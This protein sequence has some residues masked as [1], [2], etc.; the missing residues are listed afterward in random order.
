MGGLSSI[1]RLLVPSR[2]AGIELIDS[3]E[4][5]G[6]DFLASFRDIRKINRY[7]GGCAVVRKRIRPY[8]GARTSVLDVG[9]GLADIPADLVRWGTRRGREIRVVGLDANPKILAAAR[10]ETQGVALMKASAHALPFPDG[11]FD[12]VVSSLT[13]HHFD[14]PAA[15]A[16]LR[17]MVRVARR[18]VIVNDL[19]RGYLPAAL[20]WLVTRVA[21][22]HFLTRHDAPLSVLRSLTPPEYERLARGS[23]FLDARVYRH[24]FWRVAVVVG[25]P[26]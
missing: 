1:R 8:L 16:A 15:A 23:G 20:I 5:S 26:E 14:E 10:R 9:T 17:E 18:V 25:K 21:R 3:Y 24:P 4:H 22:M 19:Q 6:R 12:V 2:S 11:S 7:L 13:F